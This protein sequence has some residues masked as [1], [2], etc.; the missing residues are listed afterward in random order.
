[1]DNYENPLPGKIYISPRLKDFRQKERKVRIASKV[2]EAPDAYAFGT[3]KD[4]VVIRYR[5]GQKSYITAKFFE[6]DREI[7]VL[8][9]Q[10]YSVATDKPH[11]ASFSFVGKEIETLRE[12]IS[13]VNGVEFSSARGMN[14]ADEELAKLVRRQ[15]LWDRM[16][17]FP[18]GGWLVHRSP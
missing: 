10:G 3:I 16:R 14:I 6:D 7:F 18:N 8:S 5:E 12:F 4:E 17:V 11:N 15:H 9:I 1:M 2:I 13:N